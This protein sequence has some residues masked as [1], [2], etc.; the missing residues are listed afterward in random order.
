M[1][2]DAAQAADR[3]L[4]LL[5]RRR[6]LL[7]DDQVDL[8]RQ[9][10]HRLVEA[11]QALGGGEPAQRLAHL[12]KSALKPGQRGR[13]DARLAAVVDALCK[14]LDLDLER[15]HGAA[16]QRFGELAADLREVGTDRR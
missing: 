15:F 7:G 8:L 11:D 1:R 14:R 16:R 4:E 2:N 6:V 3:R 13:I 12:R 5:Q 9:R 10:I